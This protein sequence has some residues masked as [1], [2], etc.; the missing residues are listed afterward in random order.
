MSITLL[1]LAL[2]SATATAGQAPTAAPTPAPPKVRVHTYTAASRSYDV[3][4]FWLESDKGLV[5]IDALLLRSD[6]RL[7]AAAMKATGKPLAGILLTHPHLDH[8]GGLRTVASAFGK[9]PVYATRATAHAIK[10]THDQAMAAGWPQAYG[11]DYDADPY[12]PDRLIES[13][14]TL[15]LAG[16]KFEVRDYGPMEAANNSVIHNLDLNILFT[17][18]ATVSHAGVYVGEGRSREVLDVLERL[19]RDFA[20]VRRVFSGHYAPAAIAPL[21][22]QNIEDVRFYRSAVAAQAVDTASVTDKGEL[23]EAARTRAARAM[24]MRIR[25]GATYG[26]DA[27]TLARMNLGGLEAAPAGSAEDAARGAAQAR[28]RGGPLDRGALPSVGAFGSRPRRRSQACP[29]RILHCAVRSRRGSKV[30]RGRNASRRLRLSHGPVLRRRSEA[31]SVLVDR[32]RFRPARRLRGGLRFHGGARGEQ[33]GHGKGE[34]AVWRGLG[35]AP[36]VMPLRLR[37]GSVL[38]VHGKSVRRARHACRRCKTG[39]FRNGG[40]AAGGEGRQPPR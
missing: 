32:R 26:M 30:S 27:M 24:A 25:E 23:T 40:R 7:L 1:G 28:L 35:S 34:A 39:P 14:T 15:E 6:A 38:A 2:L 10:P 13:G 3:N 22:A 4:A 12:V 36:R 31:V 5:L 33:C 37:G 8:F 16:M 20:S 11:A 18:D 21:I 17:G 19:G 9:V 29:A